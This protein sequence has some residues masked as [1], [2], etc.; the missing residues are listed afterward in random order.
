MVG[1]TFI[2][3]DFRTP[4]YSVFEKSKREKWEL[5][6]GIGNS[7]GYNQFEGEK[8]YIAIDKL[9]RLFVDLVSKNGNMLLN[10]GPKPDGTIPEIQQARLKGLGDWLKM[11][12][13]GIFGTRPWIRAQD[14]S[15]EKIPVRFTA[16]GKTIYVFLLQQPS[17]PTINL[18]NFQIP[19]QSTIQILG[20]EQDLAWNSK[21]KSFD[22]SIPIRFV[23]QSRLWTSDLFSLNLKKT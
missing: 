23:T 7:F 2:H 9:I 15:Q 6:R 5:T 19:A 13:K 18:N 1:P 10:I 12:G 21:R 11:N 22:P 17:T 20:I 4:E 8:D 3:C 14:I 16:K